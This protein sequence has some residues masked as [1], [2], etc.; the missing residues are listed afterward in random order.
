MNQ[1][2]SIIYL[3]SISNKLLRIGNV[4]NRKKDFSISN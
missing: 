1:K 4:S 3:L 2:G